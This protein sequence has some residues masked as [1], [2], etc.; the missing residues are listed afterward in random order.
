MALTPEDVSRVKLGP[1]TQHTI[2]TLRLLKDFFGV[3]FKITQHRDET[4][5]LACLGSG[6]KNTSRQV[7]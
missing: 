2:E 4:V 5:T 7:T 1:L 3:V 6:F